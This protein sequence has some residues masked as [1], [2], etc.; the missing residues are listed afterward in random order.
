MFIKMLC[1]NAM[2]K[3]VLKEWFCWATGY[4]SLQS[5]ELLLLGSQGWTSAKDRQQ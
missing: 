1:W 2:L 3:V 5:C 4:G